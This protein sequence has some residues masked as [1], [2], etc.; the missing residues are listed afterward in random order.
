MEWQ[1]REVSWCCDGD[2][3]SWGKLT[4][5]PVHIAK[6]SEKCGTASTQVIGSKISLITVGTVW[7][8]ILFTELVYTAKPDVCAWSALL[9][10]ST[11]NKQ[12]N[13]QTLYFETQSAAVSQ[14]PK[15]ITTCHMPSEVQ[16]W[17][18]ATSFDGTKR[19]FFRA[20]EKNGLGISHFLCNDAITTF[21]LSD[22][23]LIQ[24]CYIILHTLQWA[25]SHSWRS[26]LVSILPG[27]HNHIS[28]CALITVVLQ[29]L[30]T[31]A[32]LD[33][34]LQTGPLTNHALTRHIGTPSKADWIANKIR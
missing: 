20:N 28:V 7:Y 2:G 8:T 9:S 12:T 34:L 31:E 3:R 30:G 32:D 26:D 5:G 6:P 4:D 25:S 33:H 23:R 15:G 1:Q 21:V 17:K 11:N 14:Y 22:S 27:D 24:R 19:F 18:L 13:K 16:I 29:C 10:H